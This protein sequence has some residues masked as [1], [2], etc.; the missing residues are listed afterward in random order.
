MV[1]NFNMR[2]IHAGYVVEF[3]NGLQAMQNFCGECGR[4]LTPEAWAMLE[5]RLRGW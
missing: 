1:E 5:K 2:K 3:R 4:P